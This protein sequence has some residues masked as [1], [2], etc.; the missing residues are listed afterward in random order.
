MGKKKRK[1]KGECEIKELNK[2]PPKNKIF[3]PFFRTRK[4]GQFLEGKE[5]SNFLV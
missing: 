5:V 4:I 3:F 1:M 2:T